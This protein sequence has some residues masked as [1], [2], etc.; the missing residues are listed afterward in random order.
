VN[1][2]LH[3][4]SYLNVKKLEFSAKTSH[5]YGPLYCAPSVHSCHVKCYVKLGPNELMSKKFR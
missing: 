4:D 2:E 1:H 3:T 5:P